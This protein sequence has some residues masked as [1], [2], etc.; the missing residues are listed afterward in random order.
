M[1]V[2][3]TV[4]VCVLTVYTNTHCFN[5]YHNRRDLK[6]QLLIRAYHQHTHDCF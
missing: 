2:I 6:T 3:K 4:G 5:N 1:I